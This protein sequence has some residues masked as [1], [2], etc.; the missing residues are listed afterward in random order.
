MNTLVYTLVHNILYNK[1]CIGL[2]TVL[3]IYTLHK[4]LAGQT[5]LFSA[6]DF[7]LCLFYMVLNIMLYTVLNTA[8]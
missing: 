3:S 8:L 1:L 6:E 5:G 2:F 7:P 4:H